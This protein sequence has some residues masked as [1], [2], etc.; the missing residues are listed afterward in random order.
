MKKEKTDEK[1]REE[2]IDLGVSLQAPYNSDGTFREGAIQERVRRAKEI[3]LAHKMWI[4]ALVSAV[5]SAIS[6]LAA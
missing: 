3:K 4:V 6:A 5:A 1:L 2:A